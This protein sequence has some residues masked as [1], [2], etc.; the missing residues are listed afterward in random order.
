VAEM[1][2]PRDA[3]IGRLRQRVR[4]ALRDELSDIDGIARSL[5]NLGRE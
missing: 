4:A 1:E 3:E 5:L 2:L